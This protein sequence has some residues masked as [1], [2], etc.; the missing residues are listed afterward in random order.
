MIATIKVKAVLFDLDGTLLDT[1]PDLAIVLNQIR[2]M[3]GLPEL[4]LP[5]IKPFISFGSKV[6]IKHI[7][8]VAEHDER[9]QTMRELLFTTYA[10]HCHANTHFFPGMEKVL[11]YLDAQGIC[12]G[13]VTNRLTLHTDLLLTALKIKHL[14]KC[15]VCGDTL[16][17]AK[18]NPEPILHACE[19]LQLRPQNC[20]YIG[21]A[22][23]DIA[24]GKAAG[25]RTLVALYGY[26]GSDEDP[27]EWNADGYLH[28]P[29][30]LIDW[31]DH[32]HCGRIS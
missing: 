25:L 27:Y 7:L 13:I 18:P 32:Q 24:A 31:I 6:L 29:S 26:I 23:S 15:I 10:K 21:D 2:K 4:L 17:T 30:E 16:A 22:P 8:N 11:A 28:E 9:F 14:P 12:W 1:A 19:I 20:I 3:H 5:A